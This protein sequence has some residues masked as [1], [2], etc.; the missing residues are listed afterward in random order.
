MKQA[1]EHFKTSARRPATT[2]DILAPVQTEPPEKWKK[3]YAH[4]VEL[5][6]SLLTRQTQLSSDAASELPGFST[7]NADAGT[8]TYDR[9]LALSLLSSEQNALY[10]IEQALDRI[11]AGTY[12]ICEMTGEKIELE[13]LKAVP[14]ARFSLSAESELEKAGQRKR[15]RL[16][17]RATVAVDADQA[18]SA[19]EG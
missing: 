5:R 7:H 13:R 15:A 3:H 17:P 14:W 19:E 18:E 8:D 4:L 10:Q 9:D 1:K 11:R 12:G 6:E 2:A 16:G